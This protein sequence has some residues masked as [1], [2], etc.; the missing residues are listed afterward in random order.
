MN[1]VLLLQAEI[2]V[3]GRRFDRALEKYDG[4]LELAQA[5]GLW[6]E[7]G[8]TCEHYSWALEYMGDN[9]ESKV[10]LQKAMDAY[11]EWGSMP[12]VER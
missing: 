2:D 9:T 1:K 8:L 5:E 3:F 7:Y 12:K 6:N 10:M 11:L 4:A